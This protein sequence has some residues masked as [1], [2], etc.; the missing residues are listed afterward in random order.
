LFVFN[1]FVILFPL[2]QA[3]EQEDFELAGTLQEQI[4]T[5]TQQ[6]AEVEDSAHARRQ[7][8]AIL[9]ETIAARQE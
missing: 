9:R 4:D 8:V 7:Q 5:L 1:R 6:V 2:F 3:V